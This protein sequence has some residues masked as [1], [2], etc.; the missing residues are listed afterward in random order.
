M[1]SFTNDKS[2]TLF[3]GMENI[4]WI[5]LG[6]F[7]GVKYSTLMEIEKEE[8]GKI[9]DLRMLVEWLIQKSPALQLIKAC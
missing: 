3:L 1:L 7:L 5:H 4:S 8:R 9:K 2:C 6:L